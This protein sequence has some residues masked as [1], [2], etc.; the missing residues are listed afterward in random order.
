[1]EVAAVG[2]RYDNTYDKAAA[3]KEQLGGYTLVN[4]TASY[5]IRPDLR[6]EGRLNN[7]FD[8]KYETARYYNTE[9]FTAFV[10]L[11]YSPK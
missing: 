5:A 7:L 11:R 3:N 6:L 1:M 10:G 8:K 2:R 4:L 9:G